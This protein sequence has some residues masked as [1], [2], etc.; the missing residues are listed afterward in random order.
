MSSSSKTLLLS[1]LYLASC[2]AN[3]ESTET[4][5]GRPSCG[6]CTIELREVVT[7]GHPD[8]PASI[9]DY[10]GMG[11]QIGA[12]KTGE[13]VASG[14][15]GGG[16]LLVYG[17][18]GR[19]TRTIGR[20]G[21]GPGEFGRRTSLLIIS[22]DTIHVVD[23]GNGRIQTLTGEGEFIRSVPLSAYIT[24]F[25]LLANGDFIV[26]PWISPRSPVG[27][28]LL[29]LI[30][31]DGG[32]ARELLPWSGEDR[33]SE[34]VWMVSGAS[35]SG[36]WEAGA[37][38]YEIT[39]RDG[40]GAQVKVL[41]RDVEWFPP[42]TVEQSP[43]FAPPPPRLNYFREDEEGRLWVSISVPDPDFRRWTPGPDGEM[44]ITPTRIH[45]SY[46]ILL[47]VIDVERRQIVASAQ[48][49]SWISPMCNSPLVYSLVETDSGDIRAAVFEPTLRGGGED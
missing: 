44:P 6:D 1:I 45:D 21:A 32:P 27:Q 5:N 49:D 24:S 43:E 34:K 25:A 29:Q 48:F 17:G 14:I 35:G 47:E 11:C 23:D 26:H 10:M 9:G 13:F 28:P 38:R 7:L 30:P 22:G 12:L 18:D 20:A 3:Q 46:D 36:F 16:M 2:Q 40:S 19:V 41:K 39:A 31:H 15:T 8:D 37:S 33:V 4:I 42:G